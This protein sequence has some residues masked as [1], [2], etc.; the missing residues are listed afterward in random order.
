LEND[1]VVFFYGIILPAATSTAG[2]VH[3]PN[4][5]VDKEKKG[6]YKIIVISS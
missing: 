6:I 5:S 4:L 2:I 1:E 3:R